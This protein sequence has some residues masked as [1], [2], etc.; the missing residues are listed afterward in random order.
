[1]V[2]KERKRTNNHSFQND[3]KRSNLIINLVTAK[4]MLER[5]G[6]Q[7]SSSFVEI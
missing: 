4:K 5:L 3:Q 2:G 6:I 1:M 7:T